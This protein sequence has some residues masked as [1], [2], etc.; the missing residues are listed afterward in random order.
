M[1]INGPFLREQEKQVKK[2]L[3][4]QDD[5]LFTRRGVMMIYFLSVISIFRECV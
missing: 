5:F 4:K 1:V 3:P 2:F